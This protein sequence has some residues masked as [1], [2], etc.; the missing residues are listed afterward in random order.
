L[1]GVEV[2][3]VV[4]LSGIG[5]FV[6]LAMWSWMLKTKKKP[7]TNLTSSGVKEEKK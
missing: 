1:N 4:A 7:V 5:V 3:I 2:L 6:V